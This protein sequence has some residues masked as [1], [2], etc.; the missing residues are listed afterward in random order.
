MLHYRRNVIALVVDIVNP[1]SHLF[2]HFD[3]DLFRCIALPVESGCAFHLP[4]R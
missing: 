1:E 3:S 4:A 2:M